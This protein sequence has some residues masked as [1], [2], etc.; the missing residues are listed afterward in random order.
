M[1]GRKYVGID[2]SAEYVSF[3]KQ[4]LT[5]AMERLAEESGEGGQ[6]IDLA[7]A[8]SRAAA[9]PKRRSKVMTPTDAFGRPRVRRERKAVKTA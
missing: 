6:N 1:L 9:D 4:R 2:Q 8:A 3:A 7:A 5:G